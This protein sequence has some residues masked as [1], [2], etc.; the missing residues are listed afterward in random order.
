M[1]KRL[2]FLAA[3]VVF[4]ATLGSGASR[5]VGAAE[6]K[7][8]TSGLLPA[9]KLPDLTVTMQ[10]KKHSYQRDDGTNCVSYRPGTIVVTNIGN[11]T[12]A[13]GYLVLIEWN[14]P[15]GSFT[16]NTQFAG[17]T[18]GPGGTM[19]KIYDQPTSDYPW[20]P[21]TGAPLPSWRVTVDH[22]DKI[23]ESNE[24]NNTVEKQY[25]P[26]AAVNKQTKPPVLAPR[27]IVPVR[28]QGAR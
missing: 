5:P 15:V 12:A 27:E 4:G 6:Q 1:M 9:L 25:Q 11:A 24:T 23:K 26:M 14:N 3:A 17:E 19:T 22:G 7:A 21:G 8:P 16:V 10:P 13:E 28:P 18:L 2:V 20:C